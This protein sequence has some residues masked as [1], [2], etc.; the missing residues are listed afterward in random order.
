MAK[1]RNKKSLF[2]FPFLRN[3]AFVALGAVVIFALYQKIIL[4]MQNS[5]R[6]R[7]RE[8]VY[9]PSLELAPS[10]RLAALK[11][12]SIFEVNLHSLQKQ[13][14]N[15][16]P[17][18]NDLRL[19]RQ[20]PD[21]IR[22][23]ARKRIPFASVQ[24]KNKD[25]LLD[26]EGVVLSDTTA[27]PRF[28]PVITGIKPAGSILIPG[29]ILNTPDLR[30]ALRVLKAFGMNRYLAAYRILRIDVE[31]LS[32]IEFYLSNSLKIMIDQTNIAQKMQVLGFLLSRAKLKLENVN[33]IDLRFK[34]PIIGEKAP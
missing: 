9:D 14:Q 4:Q 31:N 11:G 5:H 13:L 2:S 30:I 12:R 26:R 22:V 32:Q 21:R 23:S 33:Y 7:I 28:L 20:F 34:E 17:E 1:K 10:S 3:L 25:Y 19:S 18:L 27:S 15:Q 8:I 6:F 24:I 16:H 29:Q